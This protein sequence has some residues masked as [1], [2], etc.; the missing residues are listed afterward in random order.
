MTVSYPVP[1]P[2]CAEKIYF[3]VN[4]CPYCRHDFH[5]EVLA[6][7]QVAP[8]HSSTSSSQKPTAQ[9]LPDRFIPRNSPGAGKQPSSTTSVTKQTAAN[10]KVENEKV[11][12]P[13]PMPTER[14]SEKKEP[15]EQLKQEAKPVSA[16][17]NLKGT[18]LDNE[19]EKPH[20]SP[21]PLSSTPEIVHVAGK[22]SS[23]RF[24]LLLGIGSFCVA[25]LL[26][27]KWMT[28]SVSPKEQECKRLIQTSEQSFKNGD[29]GKAKTNAQQ[30]VASCQGKELDTAKLLKASVDK[31]IET[32]ARCARN[33]NRIDQLLRERRLVSAASAFKE[34]NDTCAKSAKAK[35]IQEVLGRAQDEVQMTEESVRQFI[36][37]GSLAAAFTEFE[38]LERLNVE[39]RNL[40]KLRKEIKAIR[41]ATQS[42]PP[43][44]PKQ[45]KAPTPTQE[46]P[47]QPMP[48]EMVKAILVDSEQALAQRRFDAAR[49]FAETA[50]RLD[51]SN[52]QVQPLLQ[53]I[54]DKELQVLKDET[55]IR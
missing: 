25:G 22:K 17:V 8:N 55:T 10:A 14:S 42:S 39:N 32:Q 6:Q 4:F 11:K 53:R 23:T 12:K 7:P 50:R 27:L 51:P 20:R 16:P 31:E 44:P 3:E 2:T 40:D 1:C 35:S 18:L 21:S 46:P 5:G 41:A 33:F 52:L 28:P 19:S 48:N 15:L 37:Q 54:R 13:E 26:S 47:A 34:M 24:L 9:A 45:P 30:A 38:K 29:I 36:G 43:E 49:T